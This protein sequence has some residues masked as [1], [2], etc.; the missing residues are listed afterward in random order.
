M[1][2][3]QIL[4]DWFKIPFLRETKLKVLVWWLGIQQKQLHFSHA[5]VFKPELTINSFGCYLVAKS[6]LTP[7]WYHG[8]YATR[9]LLCQWDFPAKN[10]RVGCHFI[11]Y[12]FFP[13]QGSNTYLLHYWRD[14]L[15]LSHL[16]RLLGERITFFKLRIWNTKYMCI[17]S[18][19]MS[20]HFCFQFNTSPYFIQRV[21]WVHENT[22]VECL[23]MTNDERI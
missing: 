18:C 20:L 1:L 15:P 7:L 21:N 5:V 10:S 11:L 8:L 12:G 13:T 23:L 6:Y 4:I 14:C 16:G 17:S 3:L 9:L 2:N 22:I 19:L